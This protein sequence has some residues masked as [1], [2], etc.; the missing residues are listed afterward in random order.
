V[1]SCGGGGGDGSGTSL[2]LDTSS[3]SFQ[4]V[5]ADST[6]QS[7]T[8]HVSWSGANVAGYA[9]GTLPGQTLPPWLSVTAT[10]NSSPSSVIV[11]ASAAGLAAGN[12]ST[13]L[14]VATGDIHE[15]VLNYQD[16]TISL[17]VVAAPSVAPMS[18]TFSWVESEQPAPQSFTVTHD[19]S[20]Q[21]S[22]ATVDANWLTASV[23]GDVI[24]VAGNAQSQAFPVG[25]AMTTL[26]ATFTYSGHQLTVDIPIT[27]TVAHAL[28]GP[29]QVALVVNASTVAADLTAYHA[30]IATATQ[31][32]LQVTAQSNAPWLIATGGATGAANNVSLTV[33][34]TALQQM[35]DGMH[36][37]T[38]TISAPGN[39]TP[40]QIPVSLNVQL[41]EVHFVAPVAFSDTIATDYVIVRGQGFSDPAAQL[42]LVGQPITG[43]L[44]SD[45][46][47][48]FVPGA[49]AAGS[50]AVRA[51]NNLGLTRPSANLRVTD[52]PDYHYVA[53]DV[54]VGAQQRIISSP[55][56]SM[57]FS[58]ECYFCNTTGVGDAS[59]LHRFIY[60]ATSGTWSHTEYPFTQLVD[61]GLSPDESILLVLTAT[62]LLQLDPVTMNPVAPAVTVP[63]PGA[64]GLSH[65]MAVL[66]N[67]LVILAYQGAAYDLVAKAFIPITGLASE[68]I[69]A[70]RDGSRAINGQATNSGN[71]AY[72]YFDASTNTI[73]VSNTFQH[74]SRGDYSRHAT[75]AVVNTYVLDQNLAM[76]GTVPIPSYSGDLS[77]DGSRFYGLD[78]NLKELRSFDLTT[79]GF[80]EGTPIP[81]PDIV[82]LGY[83]Q[84]ALD[85]R[86]NA[87]IVIDQTKFIV[88]DLR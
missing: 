56:N 44:V 15:N 54:T 28:S 27:A 4:A 46:E 45:T 69:Q 8:V 52:P 63:N 12:Y 64:V 26:H 38:L 65:E 84:M 43:T 19:S 88:V 75:K 35:A 6:V 78:I 87:A 18:G 37:A 32:A 3:L 68:D 85:P 17:A 22:G 67:G 60:N 72:R 58:Q 80:P 9:V 86:G 71:V 73:V 13:T 31:S 74:Y 36:T 33:D 10:G 1:T 62:Q 24:T 21:L 70:S 16:F 66:N 77:P 14:R 7:Q 40:L 47:F 48:R 41:P 23:N 5:A 57:V 39:I 55:V 50:Y 53:M 79:A 29:A 51:R 20:I 42:Q 61:I 34:A 11:T 76:I 59:A 30:T 49:H 83:E 2:Q 82:S 81:V 25:S